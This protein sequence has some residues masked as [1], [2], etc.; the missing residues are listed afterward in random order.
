LPAASR[1]TPEAVTHGS[2]KTMY[3]IAPKTNDADAAANTLKISLLGL[4][5]TERLCCKY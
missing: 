4:R 2:D 5:I 1:A 3:Q